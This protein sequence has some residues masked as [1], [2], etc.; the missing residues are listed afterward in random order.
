MVTLPGLLLFATV[1]GILF[2]VPSAL[3]VIYVNYYSKYNITFRTRKYFCVF[4]IAFLA[5]FSIVMV[6]VDA[7]FR[8]AEMWMATRVATPLAISHVVFMKLTFLLFQ[9]EEDS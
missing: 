9:D 6:V 3:V 1:M 5:Y 2:G 8:V 4:V 7:D